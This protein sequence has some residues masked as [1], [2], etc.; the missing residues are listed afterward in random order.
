MGG[1]MG[2]EKKKSS[3]ITEADEAVLVRQY[4]IHM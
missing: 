2:K 3:R 4:L 1:L